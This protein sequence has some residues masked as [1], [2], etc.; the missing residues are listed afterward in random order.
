MA[1]VSQDDAS[2]PLP[3]APE[4]ALAELEAEMAALWQLRKASARELAHLL[5]PRLD[6][7]ALPLI[8]AL[9]RS[10]A[11]RPTE[12]VRTLHL[13]P[14]TISRQLAA[15]ERL[16][17]V[18]RVPDPSDAR[19]RLVDLTAPAREQFTDFSQRQLEQW[20][21]SLAGWPPGDVEQLTKL[22]HRVRQ[23]W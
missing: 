4:G 9:G 17:L 22:L 18:T 2:A 7:T 16:G 19:A 21:R 12:L 5:H 10:G 23:N 11:M 6:P 3:G 1:R 15:V 20:R 8:A 13:D 14:S